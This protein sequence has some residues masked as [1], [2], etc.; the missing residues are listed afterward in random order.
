[1]TLLETLGGGLFIFFMILFFIWIAWLALS[2]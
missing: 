1:M 2:R